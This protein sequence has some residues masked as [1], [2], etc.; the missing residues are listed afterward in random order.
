MGGEWV[1]EGIV[2]VPIPTRGTLTNHLSHVNF[3]EYGIII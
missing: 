3:L 1:E 2:A